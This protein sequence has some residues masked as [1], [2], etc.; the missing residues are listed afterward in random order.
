MKPHSMVKQAEKR[1]L[2]SQD[3]SRKG[4][5]DVGGNQKR[6]FKASRVPSGGLVKA[7]EQKG[8]KADVNCLMNQ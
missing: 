8:Q 1:L 5:M 4:S 3:Y 7:L 6:K 2:S